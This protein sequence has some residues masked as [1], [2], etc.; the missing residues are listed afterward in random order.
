MIIPPSVTTVTNSVFYSCSSL[1]SV[2]IP[3]GVT[4]IGEGAFYNCSQLRYVNFPSSLNAIEEGGFYACISLEKIDLSM[5][6]TLIIKSFSFKRCYSL[7]QV[8]LPNKIILGK[9]VFAF[10]S[11]LEINYNTENY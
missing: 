3:A 4:S 11:D 5:C 1:K 2:T 7:R 6:K 8:I 9:D 10:V